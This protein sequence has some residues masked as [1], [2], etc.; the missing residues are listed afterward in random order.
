MDRI[1]CP[2][3]GYSAFEND[4]NQA[5]DCPVCHSAIK[6][7]RYGIIG[8]EKGVYAPDLNKSR[9][10]SLEFT[11][12]AREY[13]RIWYVNTILTIL[14]FGVY[15]A[16]AKVRTRQ[17]LYRR[18]VMD[19]HSF[20]YTA[21]PLVI[22]KGYAIVGLT[23]AA[24]QVTKTFN[25]S[26][27]AIWL[28]LFNLLLPLLIYKS[29]RF[30][31]SSTAYRN[32]HFHFNGSMKESYKLYLL[33]PILV[34]LSFGLILP[35]WAFQRKAYFFRNFAYGQTRNLFD[36]RLK[37]VYKYY[38]ETTLVTLLVSIIGVLIILFLFP[39]IPASF[40]N[41]SQNIDKE[42]LHRAATLMPLVIWVVT[43]LAVGYFQQCSY[44]WITNY[45]MGHSRLGPL[46]FQSTLVGK[47]LIW[48]RITNILAIVISVGLLT[49]WAKIRHM[50][51]IVGHMTVIA[52]SH[53]DDF[54]EA[55]DTKESAVG[56]IA[57]DL[58]AFEIGL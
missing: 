48:L 13:C 32:I 43:I 12:S 35:Y 47:E 9:H 42:E 44:A 37:P 6:V 11:G 20:E 51:Y 5:G 41:K 49:P 54:T 18:T 8:E 39:S 19:G 23:L 1:M 40:L 15:S 57:T 4:C 21:N 2:E 27:A 45:C 22:F 56:D 24:Y 29:L 50:K 38:A 16:W 28:C 3:C 10:V 58:I 46:R 52:D 33:W 31:A 25:P 34:F 17:Y 55:T 53:L 7:E 30:N 36:G 26:L 14:T